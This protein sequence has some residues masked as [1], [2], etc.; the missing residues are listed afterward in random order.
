LILNL[1]GQDPKS[2]ASITFRA[3]N[4][5]FLEALKAITS[6]ANLRYRVEG[7]VVFIEPKPDEKKPQK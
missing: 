3:T 7:S 4:M 5:T 1:K 6:S 2:I